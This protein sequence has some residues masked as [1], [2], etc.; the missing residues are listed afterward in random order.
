MTAA[1]R[2]PAVFSYRMDVS[3]F[4]TLGYF[5]SKQNSC[6]DGQVDF[7]SFQPHLDG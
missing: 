3:S 1:R 2:M 4:C 7:P 5:T 6:Q